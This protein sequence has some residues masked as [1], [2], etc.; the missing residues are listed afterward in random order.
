VVERDHSVEQIERLVQCKLSG[1]PEE[2]EGFHW[3]GYTY[4]HT[5]RVRNLSRAMARQLGADE[6]AVEFAALL[7]D[8]AKPE[9]EPHAAA[10]AERAEAVLAALGIGADTRRQVAYIIRTHVAPDPAYPIENLVLSDADYIDANFGCVAFARFIT[11]RAH[12]GYALD[13]TVAGASE[14][15][16]RGDERREKVVTELGRALAHERLDCMRYVLGRLQE[17]LEGAADGGGDAVAVARYLAADAHRPSLLRQVD[18]MTAALDGHHRAGHL[19]PSP[20]LCQFVRALTD[21]I[22]GAR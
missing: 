17:D 10:G 21:E 6:A 12:R 15:L 7:H 5:L 14:W 8:I 4:E 1:W 11:I 2:W 3:P 19:Q 18:E 13:E 20:F 16:S 22:A 9:G